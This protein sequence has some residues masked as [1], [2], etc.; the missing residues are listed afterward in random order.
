MDLVLTLF[1]YK[2]CLMTYK[3]LHGLASPYLARLCQPLS[4]IFGQSQLR[5]ARVEQPLVL[6]IQTTSMGSRGFHYAAPVSWNALPPLL[7][8]PK[9]S[10]TDSDRC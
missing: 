8:D 5:S 4:A 7:R 2:L 3:C 6:R 9:L 1:L 10:L